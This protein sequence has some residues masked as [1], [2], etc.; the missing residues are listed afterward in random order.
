[1]SLC[2]SGEYLVFHHQRSENVHSWMNW[3]LWMSQDIH[4][5]SNPETHLLLDSTYSSTDRRA[6]GVPARLLT[7]C[8]P[9]PPP[10]PP[11]LLV[12][13]SSLQQPVPAEQELVQLDLF[14]QGR[15]GKARRRSVPAEPGHAGPEPEVSELGAEA[16]GLCWERGACST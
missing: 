2:L 13:R 6:A 15:G 4:W 11:R 9:N 3:S 8:G 12:L 7:S 16:F 1:M 14:A 10:W 5:A